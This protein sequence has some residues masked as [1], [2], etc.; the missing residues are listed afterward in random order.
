MV[1]VA[2]VELSHGRRAV[3]SSGTSRATNGL[4]ILPAEGATSRHSPARAEQGIYPFARRGTEM[5]DSNREMKLGMFFAPGGH[6]MAAWRHPD[7]YPEGFSFAS[8]IKAAQVAERACFDMLFVA[9]VFNLTPDGDRTDS[10]RFEPITLLTALA[11]ATSKIGLVGTASSSFNEPYNIARKFASLDHISGGRAA[12]IV[13]LGL[14][15]QHQPPNA[16]NP[17]FCRLAV[18][19]LSGLHAVGDERQH[20]RLPSHVCSPQVESSKSHG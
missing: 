6:H 19:R 14:Y 8:Y 17:I 12:W 10:F 1:L 4:D 18:H 3:P 9:D 11:M 15:P 2:Q 20:A 5:G 16:I 13:A 7:A